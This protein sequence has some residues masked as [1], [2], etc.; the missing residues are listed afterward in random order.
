M[1]L[2]SFGHYF[3][4]AALAASI[5]NVGATI[6]AFLEKNRR[7]P[8]K[9]KQFLGLA[10]HGVHAAW[11]LTACACA[12]LMTLFLT[13]NFSVQYVWSNSSRA[14]PLLYKI[15][16]FWGGQG[17]S[18]LMWAGVQGTYALLVANSGRKHNLVI[19]PAATAV[20]SFVNA[21]FIL[22]I[23]W[24]ANPFATIEGPL[25]PDGFGLN[26]LL[27][28]PWMQIHPPTL[29]FGYIGC[30]V[31]FAFAI[32]ALLH[33][34]FDQQWVELVRRWTLVTWIILFVGI[35]MGG[36]WAYE[37]LGWGG[38]W[39]WDPV[40]NASL[41][42][43]L[44]LTAF[45]HSIMLQGR[46]GILKTWNVVLVSLS[47]LLSIFGTF[48]TR[49][50]I[51]SSVHSFAE[52][53]IG[54]YFL[55]FLGICFLFTFGLIWLKRDELHDEAQINSM[56]SREGTM[57]IGNWVWLGATLA[58]LFGTIYPTIY[59]AMQGTRITVEQSYFNQVVTPF[60]LLI[61]ALAGIGPLLAWQKSK[62]VELIR[63]FRAPMWV[64]IAGIPLFCAPLMY[65]LA[66]PHADKW[67]TGAATALFLVVFL[68]GAIGSEFWRGAK[69]RQ[70]STNENFL[71]AL[72]AL[73]LQNRRRYGGYI[74]HLG[75]GLFFI[76]LTGSSVFK[77]ELEP[78]DLKIGEVL[79][80]GEYSLRFDGFRR[81][82]KMPPQLVS[83]VAVQMTVMKNGQPLL[84]R[85]GKPLALLPNIEIF[86]V[87]GIENTGT[88]PNQNEQ[89]ARRPAIMTNLAHDLYLALIG[90]DMEQGTATI[91]AYLNPLVMW[92]WIAVG[93]FISGTVVCLIPDHL[94]SRVLQPRRSKSELE[95]QPLEEQVGVN[96]NGRSQDK[97]TVAGAS[98]D[99]DIEIEIAV[100][101][102]RL[103]Q[104]QA[105]QTPVQTTW[106]CK[107]GRT[108][109]N[110]DRF[111]GNCGTPR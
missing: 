4:L 30:T 47:F 7:D 14:Q 50:G 29:Y 106:Q 1:T 48:L 97:V 33:G 10:E 60:G 27:L 87:T 89:T 65:Y 63:K 66:K 3:L 35:V 101:R 5:F 9:H 57:L 13:D 98:L 32:A 103:K 90:Y 72:L 110:E 75:L 43:W 8:A 16:A 23:V 92:I 59:E 22:L 37:T 95:L 36:I 68:F 24:Q 82:E 42:P 18:L 38:Y 51:V 58:V 100:A 78:R 61:L 91:K 85:D 17:G 94:G 99:Q 93:F 12:V 26:P 39:A 44:V 108:M 102:A 25:P 49:S 109:Q 86:K 56:V 6:F 67:S 46:R 28:N 74:V 53:D 15:S 84:G 105:K 88:M 80:I 76:G 104:S 19:A 96:G 71:S 52:S 69:A 2:P 81:P 34:R 21:F 77:I 64:A 62:P 55:V 20:I 70:R 54:G 45:L 41:M 79:P 83:D 73:P 11:I 31:P 111:C 107:C 40:E